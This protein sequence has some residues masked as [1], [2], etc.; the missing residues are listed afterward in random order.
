MIKKVFCVTLCLFSS[1]T[2]SMV[3][4]PLQTQQNFT[5]T[6]E[7]TWIPTHDQIIPND[8]LVAAQN[9]NGPQ[10]ICQAEEH[11]GLHPGVVTEAGCTVTY[12][13]VAFNHKDYQILTGDK[14]AISWQAPNNLNRNP[15]SRAGG[16]MPAGTNMTMLTNLSQPVIGGYEYPPLNYGPGNTEVMI[17][18][19]QLQLLYICRAIM[20]NTI[21]IGKVTNYSVCNINV[22]G[23]EKT[24]STFEVLF[25]GQNETQ[26]SNVAGRVFGAPAMPAHN[27]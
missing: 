1:S 21:R 25:L 15:Y 23:K 14:T 3:L 19:D 24:T 6:H 4:P 18:S 8:A 10:Y 2:F 7:L 20:N 26:D 12:G 5:T 27:R 11:D 16:V 22:D 9:L 17:K 13:G